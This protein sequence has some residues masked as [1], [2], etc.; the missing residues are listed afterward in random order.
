M[1]NH[2]LIVPVILSSIIFCFYALSINSKAHTLQ[3]KAAPF[4]KQELL[5]LL[6][7]TGPQRLSQ[8]DIIG[9]LEQRGIAFVVEEKT[10]GE[11]KQAGSRTFLLEAI[12]RLGK[13]GGHSESY[14]AGVTDEAGVEQV[15]ADDF[16][17]LPLLEQTRHNVL[18]QAKELPNFIVNQM[19]TRSV[20]T[21]QTS[22][23]QLADTL[24]VE[25]TYQADKGEQFN[26]LRVSGKP[27]QQS[28]E[29][30]GGSTSTGEFGS[31]LTALFLPQS[32]AQFKEVRRETYRERATVV[33]D[34]RVLK[35]NSNATIQD[36]SSG[37]KTIAGYSG[38]LWIDT[39][40][41]GVLRI[42]LSYEGMPANFPVSMSENAV[43]YDWV[44]IGDQRYFLP[45]HAE[46]LMGRDSQ[47]VY[48]RNVIEFRNYHKFEAKMKV[49]SDQ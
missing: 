37:Q 30:L 16:S 20:R 1:A 38:S 21:P 46:L 45:I 48:T 14:P 36:K 34:F 8:G 17:R 29:E 18:E 41:R 44:S 4:S 10:I 6:R 13:S 11:F 32:K 28:Y 24:E 23:W 43:E 35:G 9:Q 31:M 42:E 33:Y 47:H 3:D 2:K 15:K 49:L 39:E 25:I 27:T 19:V 7:Q 40:T 22:D 5:S 12:R 26:L